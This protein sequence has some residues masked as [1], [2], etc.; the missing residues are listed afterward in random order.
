ML[1]YQHGYHAGNA[2]DIHKHITLIL[3]TQYMLKK[4]AP[5]HFF[6]THAGKGLYD[7]SH[8]QALK[9]QEFKEGLARAQTH[10]ASLTSDAWQ[11]FFQVLDACPPNHYPG[12]PLWMSSLKRSTDRH[13]VFELHPG[14]HSVL[15]S[16]GGLEAQQPFADL[17]RVVYGDGLAGLVRALPPK[18]PRLFVLIDPAYERLEE[19]DDVADTVVAALAKCR[20][21]VIL[22]WYPLLAAAKHAELLKR[23]ALLE[24]PVLQSEWQYKEKPEGWGMY[25]SGMLIINPPWVLEEQ[26]QES[27]APF[28]E[29][30]RNVDNAAIGHTL[31]RL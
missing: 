19:Y 3:T 18:T 7:L 9:K 15:A 21:A 13:T 5:I 23:M 26:L 8:E 2:A 27:L 20:H 16:Q 1:S 28:A 31:K 29:Q 17:G 14:E 11:H 22:I 4:P 12:S 10:R 24:Q 25:G 6:D 30:L